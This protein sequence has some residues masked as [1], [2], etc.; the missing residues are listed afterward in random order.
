MD[1]YQNEP[2]AEPIR[3][4]FGPKPHQEIRLEVAEEMLSTWRER[5]PKRFGDALREA[6]VGT[7]E[8]RK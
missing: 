4:S 6:M 7:V 8:D 1:G 2:P 5:D 3:V